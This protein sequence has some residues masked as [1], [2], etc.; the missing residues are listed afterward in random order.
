MD[1]HK[2]HSNYL[3]SNMRGNYQQYIN[4][5]QIN[6][7]SGAW[8]TKNNQLTGGANR[9]LLGSS[10][11]KSIWNQLHHG[12]NKTQSR[13]IAKGFELLWT[14]SEQQYHQNIVWKLT[15]KV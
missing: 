15:S 13:T 5:G 1:Q 14:H 6:I 12:S 10:W 4:I 7:G 11:S 9:L 3:V 2:S 8:Y